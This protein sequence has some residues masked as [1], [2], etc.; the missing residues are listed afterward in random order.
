MELKIWRGEEYHAKGIEQLANYL[1]IYQEKEGYLLIFNFN[2]NK[3]FKEEW[4]Q[5]KDKRILAV[6]V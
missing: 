3:T 4:I 2:K 1:D 6:W 5:Y